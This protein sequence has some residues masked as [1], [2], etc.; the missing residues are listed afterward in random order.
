MSSLKMSGRIYNAMI[1]F[2]G[3]TKSAPQLAH[4]FFRNGKVY[5]TN[6]FVMCRWTPAEE[7]EVLDNKTGEK[8]E[9]FYFWPRMDKVVAGTTIYIDDI[10][11]GIDCESNMVQD[12]DKMIIILRRLRHSVRQLGLISAVQ[13]VRLMLTGRRRFST[14]TLMLVV[15]G[16]LMLL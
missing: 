12:P 15:M 4:M 5:A 7:Y 10:G 11:L 14:L 1:K 16:V 9:G 3:G 13:M 6:S 2:A 8:I